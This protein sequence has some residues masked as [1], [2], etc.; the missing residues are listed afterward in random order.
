[1]N[2]CSVMTV[3]ANLLC[4]NMW[5]ITRMLFEIKHF[6]C[7]NFKRIIISALSLTALTLR[8]AGMW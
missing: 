1:M 2:S 5:K 8:L 7:F 4:I 6:K 3:Y